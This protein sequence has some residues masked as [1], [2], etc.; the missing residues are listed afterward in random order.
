MS[1]LGYK[2]TEET[3]RKI[4]EVL[5]GHS[6]SEE[7]RRKIS[8][9]SNGGY[10]RGRKHTEETK[11]K[12]SKAAKGKTFSEETRRKIGLASKGRTFS[13]EAK[14]KMGR[15]HR[16]KPKSE[17]TRRK[18]SE[19]ARRNWS[20]PEFLNSRRKSW[21][22]LNFETGQCF[23]KKTS[24]VVYWRSSWEKK[25]LSILEE[26]SLVATYRLEPFAIP[27]VDHDGRQ[28]SYIPDYE[29]ILTDG[30]RCLVEVHPDWQWK[31]EIDQI[32]R[33]AAHFFCENNGLY[34]LMWNK[35][36]LFPSQSATKPVGYAHLFS[37]LEGSETRKVGHA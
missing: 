28:R 24:Q 3:K 5:Q 13:E 9:A 35:E 6:V 37:P 33:E 34:F 31:L 14:E 27:Y 25:A 36:M 16:G 18:M 4:S 21:P 8:E 23:S 7:T 22:N 20:N 32:K 26:C 12:M 1:F 15:P 10:F 29:V 30:R 19:A 17:A 11:Q 2:H